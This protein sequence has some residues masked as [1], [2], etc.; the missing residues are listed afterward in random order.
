MQKTVPLKNK[1]LDIYIKKLQDFGVHPYADVFTYINVKD[2]HALAE[3][4]KENGLKNKIQISNGKIIDGRNRFIACELAGVKK[5]FE[6]IDL[7]EKDILNHVMSLNTHRRHLSES[8]RG[9]IA[10]NIYQN[11][12][13]L[14][15]EKLAKLMNVSRRSIGYASEVQ[16][17]GA[18][19]LKEAIQQ[20][21]IAITVA[22]RISKFDKKTQSSLLKLEHEKMIE[23]IKIM[24]KKKNQ[25]YMQAV[26]FDVT[27]EELKIM[28][29]FSGGDMLSGNGNKNFDLKSFILKCMEWRANEE[30]DSSD[31]GNKEKM[32]K[33]L[34]LLKQ[35][36]EKTK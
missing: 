33:V 8:Q 17:N 22:A 5:E 29:T 18:K 13:S 2:I 34:E 11:D 35:R 9:W 27:P 23:K 4:I 14:T 20:D 25:R 26:Q 24:E 6:K 19:E 28:D 21:K 31:T 10:A 7:P 1:N 12:K 3:N 30:K 36:P 32:N 16:H 15:Q